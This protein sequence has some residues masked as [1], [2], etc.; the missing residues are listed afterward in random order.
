MFCGL[1]PLWWRFHG[2]LRRIHRFDPS[3]VLLWAVRISYSLFSLHF[4]A[5]KAEFLHR[6]HQ[7]VHFCQE[8]VEM[9]LPPPVLEMLESVGFD[10]FKSLAD[11]HGDF[12]ASGAGCWN[13]VCHFAVPLGID[14][15]IHKPS[16]F[17]LD[18]F[19]EFLV[20]LLNDLLFDCFQFQGAP[21]LRTDLQKCKNYFSIASNISCDRR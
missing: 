5:L 1:P 16:C 9:V 7:A 19:G 18:P 6:C 11:L 8:L 2:S 4:L 17:L 14:Y 3:V 15:A 21:T 20:G 10:D 12:R 13:L